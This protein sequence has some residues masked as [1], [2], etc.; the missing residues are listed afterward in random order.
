MK[1]LITTLLTLIFLFFTNQAT[2]YQE[3][4]MQATLY[5]KTGEVKEVQEFVN[6]KKTKTTIYNK[7]GEVSV[8]QEYVNGK[9]SKTTFYHKT[10]EVRSVKEF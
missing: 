3:A 1:K 4:L 10:G 6:G 2:S 5:Y 7:A 8:V 9:K